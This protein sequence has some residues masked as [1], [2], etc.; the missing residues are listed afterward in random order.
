M[1]K[2]LDENAFSAKGNVQGTNSFYTNVKTT[3]KKMY[4]CLNCI[5]V[6]LNGGLAF[7]IRMCDARSEV[8]VLSER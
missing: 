2:E 3:T 5:C 6:E 1:F 4:F 8:T 7:N